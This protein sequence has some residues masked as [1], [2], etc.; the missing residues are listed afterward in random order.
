MKKLSKNFILKI[1]NNLFKKNLKE[2]VYGGND[3]IITTFAIV[4]GFAGNGSQVTG[5]SFSA[6]LL[7]GFANL[8]ADGTSMG[9]GSFLSSRSQKAVYETEKSKLQSS[10]Q[11][12]PK[13]LIKLTQNTFQNLGYQAQDAEQMTSLICKNKNYWETFILNSNLKFTDVENE[14]EFINGVVTFFAFLLFGFIPLIPYFF[15]LE[16][17]EA[18]YLSIFFVILSLVFL[19]YVRYKITQENLWK[20]LFEILFTGILASSLA[21]FVGWLFR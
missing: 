13:E 11:K 7:F 10:I 20:S 3:G 19:G 8:F 17:F 4:A 12:N 1:Q 16:S 21:F 15:D 2:I 18:F 6:V 14:N 9:L 5:I